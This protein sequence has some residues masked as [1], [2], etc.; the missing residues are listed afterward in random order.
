MWGLEDSAPPEL[1][2]RLLVMFILCQKFNPHL[3]QSLLILRCKL[4]QREPGPDR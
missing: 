3:L 4:G 2:E 1:R